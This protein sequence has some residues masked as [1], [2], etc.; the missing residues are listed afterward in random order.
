MRNSFHYITFLISLFSFSQT[1]NL[2]VLESAE[3]KDKVKSEE[4]ISMHSTSLNLTAVIRNSKKNLM[5]DVFN[6][7]LDRV[8]SI[9][10]PI[11]KKE[12]VY[13]DLAFNNTMKVFTVFSSSKRERVIN[14][15]EFDIISGEHKKIELFK[16][17]VDKNRSLFSGNNKRETGLAM[18]P[19]GQYF[20]VSTDNIKKNSNSYTLHVFNSNTLSLIYKKT[21][22]ENLEKFY[23]ANDLSIDDEM[24]VYSLGKLFVEGKK[25]KKGGKANYDFVL[26]K[27]SDSNIKT[28]KVD[29]EKEAFISS[30]I[31]SN[32]DNQIKLIGFYSDKRA[33]KIKGTLI[34]NVNTEDL[35]ITENKSFKLPENV[36]KDLYSETRAK[37]KKDNNAELSNYYV[38]YVITDAIGNTYLLAEEFYITDAYVSNG[39]NGG[40]YWLTTFHYNNVLV[41]K[42]NAEGKLDWG[43]SIFKRAGNPSYGA[44][45]KDNELHVILNSGKNL[46]EKDDGRVKVSKGWLESTALYDIVF[47]E[48]GNV[49]HNKIQDNK[50]KTFYK[51]YYGIFNG[52]RFITIS[53][54]GGKKQFLILE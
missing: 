7:S 21:F 6:E 29:F 13:G 31:L 54:S 34:F 47:D 1:T 25:D 39:M 53:K 15:Y 27:I 49:T 36:Y 16:A 41:L 19:N 10:V 37:K 40:G 42:I 38:D 28:T 20:V 9:L 11:E 46:T 3:F 43:R 35:T 5:F 44:F 12:R 17:N 2:K 24:N 26:N 52:E 4:V 8:N 30:L 22:Q 23:E 45:V 50:G 33:G 18:S 48:I 51:P 32:I 14:C